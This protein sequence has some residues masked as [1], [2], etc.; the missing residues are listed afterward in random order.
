MPDGDRVELRGGDGSANPY[1]AIAAALAAGLDGI[2]RSL[3]PGALGDGT[4]RGRCRRPCCTRWTRSR[5]TRWSPAS[6]TPRAP[7][8]ADYFAELKREEFFDWHAR[9]ARGRS[10][11]T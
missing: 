8:V 3:D 2:E 5:P 1:L 11:A 9:S 6:W 7:G 4:G 10:T